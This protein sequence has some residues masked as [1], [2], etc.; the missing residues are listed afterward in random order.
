MTHDENLMRK[1]FGRPCLLFRLLIIT[2][3]TVPTFSSRMIGRDEDSPPSKEN[4]FGNANPCEFVQKGIPARG[5]LRTS[6][7]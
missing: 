2:G 7:N 4:Y 1:D 5:L 3:E 6:I